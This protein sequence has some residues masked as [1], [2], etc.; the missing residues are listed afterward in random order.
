MYPM[1]LTE[2]VSIGPQVVAQLP[3]WLSA[4]RYEIVYEIKEY[5][6]RRYEVLS[7]VKRDPV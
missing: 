4:L 6:A 1:N 5:R 2:P 3:Q 7:D